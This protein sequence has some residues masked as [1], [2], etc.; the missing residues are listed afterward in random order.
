MC[1]RC[2]NGGSINPRGPVA[3]GEV[4][5]TQADVPPV[6]NPARM[7]L[8]PALWLL[9]LLAAAALI[10]AAVFAVV[11]LMA[12]PPIS[13]TMRDGSTTDL[14][15]GDFVN[16]TPA[17]PITDTFLA[18]TY[19]VESGGANSSLSLELMTAAYADSTGVILV[20]VAVGVA[21]RF[22]PELRPARVTLAYNQTGPLLTATG[23]DFNIGPYAPLNV[24]ICT[25]SCPSEHVNVPGNGS[26]VLT[27]NLVNETG[28]LP[29][30]W[31]RYP[32]HFVLEEPPG[33]SVFA[34]FQANVTGPFTPSVGVGIL[35]HIVDVPPKGPIGAIGVA[36]TK[37]SDGANWVLTFT[38]VPKGL[39]NTTTLLTV[40][41]AT[42]Q[43]VVPWTALGSL[44]TSAY[45]TSIV[46]IPAMPGTGIMTAGDR[47]LLT[48]AEYPAGDEFQ[49]SNRGTLLCFLTLQ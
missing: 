33:Q 13:L 8:H 46:Y 40:L 34:K 24:T 10:V 29:Y 9:V 30:F 2:R 18:T 14:L 38:T 27:S 37:S 35:L 36:I 4:E 23:E 45:R 16:A 21:G 17:G 31:F 47:I 22:V 39:S 32:A 3:H 12:P 1:L 5:G 41:N 7:P 42:G 25:T 15:A 19:A 49:L 28:A 6:R 44:Y 48:V 26:A 43:T 11:V 20:Q